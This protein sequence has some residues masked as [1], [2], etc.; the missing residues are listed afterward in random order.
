MMMMIITVTAV[1]TKADF[2]DDQG[3]TCDMIQTVTKDP[4]PM[5]FVDGGN[6]WT[7]CTNDN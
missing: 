3:V 2:H 4:H 1:A 5:R 6:Q 7:V